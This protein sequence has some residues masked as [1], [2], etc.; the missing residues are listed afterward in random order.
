MNDGMRL[1]G[2]AAVAGCIVL[3]APAQAASPLDEL[4]EPVAGKSACFARVYDA[5][6]LQR[7]PK[8]KTTA[9][10]V[11]LKYQQPDTPPEPGKAP[12]L[13]MGLSVSQRG[14]PRPSF[15]QGGCYWDPRANRDTSDQRMIKA[16]KKDEGAVCPTSARPD[17]FESLSAEEGGVLILDRGRDRDTLMVFLD[18]TLTMVKRANRGK[19]LDMRFGADDRVFLLRRADMTACAAVENAVTEPEPGVAPRKQ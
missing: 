11:W 2:G 3:T 14:D 8:Q 19:Q 4:I 12:V 5:A 16:F 10:T 9:I 18:D 13:D 17:V 15:A 7:N 6:H 1:L